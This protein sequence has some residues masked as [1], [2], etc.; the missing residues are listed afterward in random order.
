MA[1]LKQLA[2]EQ[3]RCPKRKR[4]KQDSGDAS[5]DC[6]WGGAIRADDDT[7]ASGLRDCRPCRG[8]RS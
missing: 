2:P 5:T 1:G 4:K 8:F 6:L 3:G 7:G